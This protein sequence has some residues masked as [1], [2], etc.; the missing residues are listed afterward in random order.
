[1]TQRTWP[2]KEFN[3]TAMREALSQAQEMQNSVTKRLDE[4]WQLAGPTNIGGRV[5]ALAV[6]SDN[7]ETIFAGAALGGVFKSTDGG[8]NYLPV[9]EED[10]ALSSGA[11]AMDPNDQNTVWLGTGEANSSGDSYPGVGVYVTRD[12]GDNWNYSGLPESYHIGRVAVDPSDSDRIFVAVM[13]KLFGKNDERGVY[14]S[15]DGGESW[16][17]VFFL[18]DSTGCIDLEINPLNPDTIYA[19]MWERIRTPER[20]SVSGPTSGIYRSVNGGDTWEELLNGLPDIDN[21]GRISIAIS[22]SDPSRL[23]AFYSDHPGSFMGAYKTS[24]HGESWIELNLGNYG[25]DLY[26]S[27]GWYFGEIMVSPTN[28]NRV[29]VCGVPMISSNDG[30]TNWEYSFN[31]AHVDHHALWINPNNPNHVISGHDGGINISS[32]AGMNSD[33]FTYLPATQFYAISHDHNYPYRLY[34]G[35][36]DNGT[37]RTMTGNIN[38]WEEIYGGDGFVVEVDPTNSDRIYA[39]YQWGGL[40]RSDNGGDWFGYI[41]SDFSDDRTNWMMPYVI[42]Y[43]ATNRLYAGTYRVWRSEDYGNSWTTISENLTD[44][45]NGGALGFHTITTLA[46]SHMDANVIYAGTDDGNIWVTRDGGVIWNEVSGMIPDRWVTRVTIDP[47]NPAIVYAALSGYKVEDPLPHLFKSEDYGTTWN[48]ICEG[49]PEQPINDVLVDPEDSARL[50]VGTD[51]GVYVTYDSGLNWEALG[52][53][54]PSASVFDLHLVEE[55]RTLVAGTH[56]RSMY[57]YELGPYSDVPG[58]SVTK[59]LPEEITIQAYPNPF[60]AFTTVVINLPET[61]DVHI[62]IIDLLGRRVSSLCNESLSAGKHSFTWNGSDSDGNTLAS[63]M[64]ILK[65]I[66]DQKRISK[67][68]TLVK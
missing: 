32:N 34:G 65:V 66:S 28:P 25:Y 48:P 21:T 12:G 1:M 22:P 6:H 56:G 35:T 9:F 23:Y 33:R 4:T 50:Y 13:G 47:Q 19:A 7:P 62:E 61:S 43:T 14:R 63:G 67:R 2:E 60:N 40:G 27:F 20:R 41:A 10:F 3:V 11:L 57:T 38:D 30:G 53:G 42:D 64:Y 68:L 59:I 15:I 49:L 55:T 36:Q 17:N 24:S 44:G 16:E 39:C 52:E 46:V 51:Y 26:S 29:Y 58:G 45:V 31:D 5:T 54:L 37:M 8:Y 18:S